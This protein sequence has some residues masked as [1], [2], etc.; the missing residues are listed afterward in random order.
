MAPAD[1]SATTLYAG[2][3]RHPEHGLVHVAGYQNVALNLAGGP[4]AMVLHFP[5]RAMG[6][7]N[8][9]PVGDAENV[10]ADM[11]L[12]LPPP[13]PAAPGGM[14]PMGGAAGAAPRVRV[15]DHDVYTVLLAEDATLIPAAL[16]EVPRRRRPR[17]D[18][19]LLRFYTDHYPDHVFAVCC[20]DTAERRRAKPLLV[21]Y[22]PLD[23]DVLTA[24]ALDGHTG[25]PPDLA[26]RVLTDHT[27]LF[28]TDE[29]A[30]GWGWPVRYRDT[31]GPGLAPFLP[32]AVVG[33]RFHGFMPNG[34]FAIPHAAVLAGDLRAVR[35]VG[36]P[37]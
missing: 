26:D 22:V 4:N 30:D 24:P 7:D 33:A 13:A 25:G 19:G 20:F 12:A 29:A 2:R 8:F 18:H 21:W 34:D 28:G 10:L 31:A 3:L 32:D 36:P 23:P 5:A 17:L 27:V 35:R 6:P 9:V 37:A 15:F 1:F 16:E 11:A 14:A